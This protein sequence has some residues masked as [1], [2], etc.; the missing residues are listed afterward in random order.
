MFD[1]DVLADNI[2]NSVMV[3]TP[4]T[5][6]ITYGLLSTADYGRVLENLP[7]PEALPP[8]NTVRKMGT[9]FE[10]RRALDFKPAELAKLDEPYRTFWERVAAVFLS[11][12]LRHLLL[13]KF[14]FRDT[15]QEQSEALLLCDS[16]G[17]EI[18]PHTDSP[19]KL[20]TCLYYL[21][22]D[23]SQDHLGTTLYEPRDPEF[24]DAV[25]TQLDYDLFRPVAEA[26]YLPNTMVSF[27]RSDKSFHGR[28][29][30]TKTG[31]RPRWVLVFDVYRRK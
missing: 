11:R 20:V 8:I 6:A 26:R 27:K 3:H 9:K 24:S 1:V 21:A 15:G 31:N 30:V 13:T 10:Q 17:F 4:F 23:T 19:R 2:R 25:S 5:H 16:N 28:P 14:E 12:E 22:A 29:P 7:P 18:K